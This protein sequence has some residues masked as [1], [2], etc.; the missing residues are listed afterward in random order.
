M[1]RSP[2][3]EKLNPA[4]AQLID[5]NGWEVPSSFNSAEAEYWALKKGAGLMDLSHRTRILVLGKDAP[6]FL[7]GMVTND[8]KG[9]TPGQGN[10]AFLLNVQGHILADLRIFRLEPEVFLLDSEPQSSQII[11]DTLDRHIIADVVELEDKRGELACIALDGPRARETLGQ[12]GLKLPAMTLLEYFYSEE[13]AARIARVSLSGRDGVWIMATPDRA[14][15]LWRKILDAS[16]NTGVRP[17]GFEALEICRIEAGIPRYGIDITE[18]NLPQETGQMDAI[19]FTKGCYIGQEVVERIRSRGH[20]NRKLMRLV[21]DGKE[22]VPSDIPV[23]SEGQDVGTMCSSAYSFGLGK[24]IG[25][26]YLRKEAAVAG[27]RV[28]AGHLPAVIAELPLFDP[29]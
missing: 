5:H 7:H 20:V 29:S 15:E 22:T 17:V 13:L 12:A 9:L 25:L 19:S 11:T 1:P 10:H 27:S 6:R 24:S 2:L 3:L 16:S 4:E 23:F 14:A 8:V 28:M 21:F 26:G 18:K